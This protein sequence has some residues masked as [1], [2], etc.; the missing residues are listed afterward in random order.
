MRRRFK[1]LDT[2]MLT[3]FSVRESVWPH[4]DCVV[5]LFSHKFTSNVNAVYPWVPY[6]RVFVM[7]LPVYF[8]HI[9]I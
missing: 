5:S 9:R 2:F 3:D 4:R 8:I 6:L 1:F 7:E